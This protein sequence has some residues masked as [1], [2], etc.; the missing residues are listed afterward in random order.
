M[1]S[2]VPQLFDRAL[3]LARQKKASAASVPL[4]THVAEE[5]G[6]RLS[7]INHHFERVLLIAP[8][9]TPFEAMLS[10]SGKCAAIEFLEPQTTDDLALPAAAY[11]AV[12][13]L[14][15]LHCGPI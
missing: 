5:L 14:L 1:T 13:S 11:D 10:A 8:A 7:V 15:D 9:R 4:L 2:T 6:E 12:F 3:Y